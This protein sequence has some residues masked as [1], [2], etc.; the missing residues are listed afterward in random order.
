[1][2]LNDTKW[3]FCPVCGGKTRI[4]VLKRT[5]L[6]DFPLYCPK[7]RRENLISIRNMVITESEEL[8]TN[9]L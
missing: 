4:R 6:I 1:M 5:V 3:V 8:R 7:C 2:S 9:Y